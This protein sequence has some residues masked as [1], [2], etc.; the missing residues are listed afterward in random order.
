MIQIAGSNTCVLGTRYKVVS[1]NGTNLNN[2][3][4]CTISVTVTDLKLYLCRAHVTN[5][6]V[7]RSISQTIALKQWCPYRTSLSQGTSNTIL[8][9][10]KQNRRITH[11]IIAFT[12]NSQNPFKS[13]PT[14]FSSG[15]TINADDETNTT[16]DGMSLINNVSITIGGVTY[17][18]AVCNLSSNVSTLTLF[19]ATAPFASNTNDQ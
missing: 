13:T 6:Y 9:P 19:V 10:M 11:I 4:P 1:G 18:Q 16:T 15:F 2:I 14:D 3:D 17:P 8:A 5:A 12:Q 7:S